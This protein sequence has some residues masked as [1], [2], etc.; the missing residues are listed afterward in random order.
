MD[1]KKTF[2]KD[3]K[4]Y[5]AKENFG[6]K[7]FHYIIIRYIRNFICFGCTNLFSSFLTS[8]LN[9]ELNEL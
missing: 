7:K 4:I 5:L 1:L 2:S 9:L 3:K 6:L 8:K